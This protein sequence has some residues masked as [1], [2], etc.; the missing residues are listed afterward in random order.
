MLK[1]LIAVILLMLSC[2]PNTTVSASDLKDNQLLSAKIKSSPP[3]HD[4]LSQ[5][6]IKKEATQRIISVKPGDIFRGV[7]AL[8]EPRHNPAELTLLIRNAKSKGA[9]D[10][11]F[12]IEATAVMKIGTVQTTYGLHG[13]YVPN[14]QQMNLYEVEDLPAA[15]VAVSTGILINNVIF[16]PVGL[17][18]KF[19]DDGNTIQCAVA[20]NG[21]ASLER[22]ANKPFG[23]DD[24]ITAISHKKSHHMSD[25]KQLKN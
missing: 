3:D 15:S 7:A 12:E 4:W 5:T 24:T 2:I 1:S 10:S 20:Y 22:L 9:T 21:N 11:E 23:L 8:S 6:S 14:C 19:T 18:G 13:V 17:A 16:E 25:N